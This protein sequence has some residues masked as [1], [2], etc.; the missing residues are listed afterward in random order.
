MHHLQRRPRLARF[1]AP[2]RRHEPF[3]QEAAESGA[4]M[5]GTKIERHQLDH[6]VQDIDSYW[7]QQIICADTSSHAH[8]TFTYDPFFKHYLRI[9]TDVFQDV[10][11]IENLNQN[12]A[13]ISSLLLYTRATCLA[14]FISRHLLHLPA[15]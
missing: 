3:V 2:P 13:Y 8:N 10:S 15:R 6:V 7:A 14:Y 11:S 4:L 5:S 9:Y 1:H 12:S